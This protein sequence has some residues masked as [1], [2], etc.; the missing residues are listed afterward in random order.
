[1]K[2]FLLLAFAI[3]VVT[4]ARFLRMEEALESFEFT[5]ASE[6]NKADLHDVVFAIKQ[7]NLDSLD[8]FLMEVSTPGSP[9][10]GKYL[11]RNEVA[12]IT[13]HPEATSL[14]ENYLKKNGAEVVRKTTYGEYITARA[15]IELWEKLFATTFY[16]FKHVNDQVKPINRAV[17]YSVDSEIADV[18]SAVFQT[19]QFPHVAPPKIPMKAVK[20]DNEVTGHITPAKLNS[21]YNIFTNTGSSSASQAVFES[22]GQYYSPSDL[23]LFQEQYGIP[24]QNVTYDIGGYESDSECVEDA[25]NCVEANLDVQYLMAISQVTPT[26]YWYDG[27]TDSFL[28]WI[29]AVASSENPPLVN[30][31]S[32]GA[33]ET[34]IPKSIANAFNT[35]AMKLGTLGVTVLVSSG[36]DGVAGSSARYNVNKC[37]YS[38]SFPATSVYVTAVGATQGA[39]SNDAETAC[40]SNTGGVI[41]TGGGFST[42][43][44]APSWQ[45]DTITNYFKVATRA[46]TGYDT[47]GRGYPDI[48]LAGLNYEVVVGGKTYAV[49]GTSASSPSVAAMVSLVN[50]ARLAAGK[51]ALGFLNPTIY[52]LGTSFTNDVTVGENNCTAGSVCCDQGFYA[53]EGWDPL[54]GFGSVDFRKFYT[55]AMGL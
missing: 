6:S 28:D 48:S 46:K 26:T 52:K 47:N 4:C 39:E 7:R 31:I 19:T 23:T 8:K 32:Y 10:Y 25:N 21:Y 42:Q 41:T 40:M 5:R 37:G 53:A 38:P 2:F 22:I 51:S 12:T 3:V 9:K 49:S 15:P 16:S 18:V 13:A 27:A 36:D 30:S 11:T 35:E 45:T 33:T 1:M 24:L 44:D 43:Y 29:Q 20:D 14:I 54:T 34:S 17:H 50:A 55:V